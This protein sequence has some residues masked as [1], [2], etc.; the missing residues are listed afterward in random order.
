MQSVIVMARD[1][2]TYRIFQLFFAQVRQ[3]V[4]WDRT[5]IRF[6]RTIESRKWWC[7]NDVPIQPPCSPMETRDDNCASLHPLQQSIRSNF[8]PDWFF[9]AKRSHINSI[10]LL[11]SLITRKSKI[12]KSSNHLLVVWTC[13]PHVCGAVHQP[14]EIQIQHISNNALRIKRPI[15]SFAPAVHWNDRW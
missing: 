2:R 14:C 11:I 7:W 8:Q 12:V 3:M 9:C 10:F 4:L 1:V 15:E 6:S 5:P 13:A